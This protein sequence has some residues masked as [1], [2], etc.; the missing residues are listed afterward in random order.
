ML[1]IGLFGIK[2][3]VGGDNVGRTDATLKSII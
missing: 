2:V 3:T 1:Y